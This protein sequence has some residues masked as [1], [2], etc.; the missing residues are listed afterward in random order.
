MEWISVND[1]LPESDNLFSDKV[2]AVVKRRDGSRRVIVAYTE[3]KIYYDE[4]YCWRDGVSR[5]PL[6]GPDELV[7]HWMPFPEPPEDD[8]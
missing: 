8:L 1:H 4:V 6:D 5:Y 3:N 7:T 2:L